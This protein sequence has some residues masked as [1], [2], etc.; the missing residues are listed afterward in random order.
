MA[1]KGNGSVRQ[2]HSKVVVLLLL[3]L[4]LLLPPLLLLLLLAQSLRPWWVTR[5]LRECCRLLLLAPVS[6]WALLLPCW[7]SWPCGGPFT[8]FTSTPGCGPVQGE[9]PFLCALLF[10]WRGG[11]WWWW[12]L[13]VWG[14]WPLW[15]GFCRGSGMCCCPAGAHGHV[16]QL[17]CDVLGHLGVGQCEVRAIVGGSPPLLG[18]GLR[19]EGGG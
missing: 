12:G 17:S 16:A 2:D 3:L 19:W 7:G 14:C 10:G 11:G 15:R 5:A 13:F 1:A 4:L 8:Q 9:G 6:P 18:L